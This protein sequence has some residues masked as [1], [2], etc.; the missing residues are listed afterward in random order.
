MPLAKCSAC[1]RE[2]STQAASCPNCGHPVAKSGGSE[3]AMPKQVAGLLAIL[4]VIGVVAFVIVGKQTSDPPTAQN[5]TTPPKPATQATPPKPPTQ[6]DLC[7][8]DWTKCADNEQLVNNYRNWSD[9]QVDCQY[10]ANERAKYGNPDWPWIPFGSFY[11]G[12]N[13]ISSGIATAIET[14]AQFSNG[15]GAK[16]HSRVT[17]RYDLRAK[18]VMDVNISP[19]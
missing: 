10:A 9:V 17:C 4:V 11:A 1:G 6:A 14:D 7:R 8:S 5:P 13:Y 18:R 12:N 2:V 19:R 15:F 16:V 3:F